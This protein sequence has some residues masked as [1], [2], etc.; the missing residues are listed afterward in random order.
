MRQDPFT[1]SQTQLAPAKILLA[2]VESPLS[3][4][5]NVEEEEE[6]EEEKEEEA[7]EK[8]GRK[9]RMEQQ[10]QAGDDPLGS[11]GLCIILTERHGS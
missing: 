3:S 6:K 11:K 10:Q 9:K 1:A 7:E 5:K 4:K 2:G 8:K